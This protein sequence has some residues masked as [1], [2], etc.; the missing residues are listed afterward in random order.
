MLFR[1]F[2]RI[3][4]VF[5]GPICQAEAGPAFARGAAACHL[6]IGSGNTRG[7]AAND[8]QN[9]HFKSFQTFQKTLLLLSSKI[10]NGTVVILK[11]TRNHFQSN[12]IMDSICLSPFFWLKPHILVLRGPLCEFPRLCRPVYIK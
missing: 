8:K 12:K 2:P 7:A 6:D 4:V 5:R 11:Y 10:S 9:D 3:C 1:M